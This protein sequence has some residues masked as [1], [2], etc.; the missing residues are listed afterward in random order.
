MVVTANA[1]TRVFRIRTGG[2]DEDGATCFT[3]EV[4][5]RQYIVTAD[6]VVPNV[7][8]GGAIEVFRERGWERLVVTSITHM[9]VSTFDIAILALDRP[10]SRTLPLEPT[11]DGL[12]YGQDV[13]F[14]GYPHGMSMII[15]ELHATP[16][17]FVKHAI[18]SAWERDSGNKLR[19]LLDGVNNPGFSGGPVVFKPMRDGSDFRVAGV[20]SFFRFTTVAVYTD[21]GRDT[22]VRA[23]VNA[24]LITANHIDHAVEAARRMGNG[25][26]A[27]KA[28]S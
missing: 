22:G 10:I 28:E 27:P 17:P 9:P 7:V 18:L 11:G 23:E 13:F 1:L 21:D 8:A 26:R 6:H 16:M 14:P 5:E 12:S 24:G 19:M 20:V 4:D 2:E 3:I 25:P 15:P